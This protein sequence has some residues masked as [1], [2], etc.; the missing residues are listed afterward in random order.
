MKALT[1]LLILCGLAMMAA[2]QDNSIQF[3]S[4]KFEAFHEV[5]HPAWHDAYPAKDYAALIASGPK[6]EAT[7]A[8]IAKLDP[9]IKNEARKASFMKE[10]QEMGE[11]V[12]K[13]VAACKAGDSQKVY[14][15]MPDMHWAFEEAMWMLQ[16]MEFKPL[17]GILVT[18]DVILDM[19]IPSDNWDGIA[20]STETLQMKLG[21]ISDESFPPELASVKD[22]VKADFIKA[23]PMVEQMKT[24]AE[25]KDLAGYRDQAMQLKKLL[26][27]I[28]EN[29]L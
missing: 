21:H 13:Y 28:R 1:S 11:W 20:G 15:I 17:D 3:A 27:S 16:P 19:H 18:V 12:A 8:P 25:K 6:F 24:L 7:Y 2:A 9:A 29:Y 5:M 22:A 23:I 14:E 4:D 26:V 10:R